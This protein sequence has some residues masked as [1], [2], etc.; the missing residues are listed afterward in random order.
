VLVNKVAD[1]SPAERAAV[2]EGDVLL[3]LN[4]HD[5]YDVDTLKFRLATLSAGDVVNI[6]LW[7]DRSEKTLTVTLA[8]L[9]EIPARDEM[10]LSGEQP[11]TGLRVMNINPAVAEE[12]NLGE[13]S[14]GVIVTGVVDNSFVARF[15]L[16]AGDRVLSINGEKVVS[17]KQLQK[18]LLSKETRWAIAVQRGQQML[19]IRIN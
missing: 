3:T 15:G 1:K 4:G 16:Q 19:Q 6:G 17:V 7:R 11:L 12:F 14:G 5:L 13:E 8:K 9:A 18:L 10:V 2:R